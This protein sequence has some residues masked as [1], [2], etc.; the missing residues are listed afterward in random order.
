MSVVQHVIELSGADH[1][2]WRSL[3]AATYKAR[4]RWP[5]IDSDRR[6]AS[7]VGPSPI[8]YGI[9]GLV[10]CGLVLRLPATWTTTQVVL[11]IVMLVVFVS[12]LTE[13]GATLLHDEFGTLRCYPVSDRTFFVCR[14]TNLLRWTGTTVLFVATPTLILVLIREGPLFATGLAVTLALSS[15]FVAFASA[16]LFSVAAGLKTS[17]QPWAGAA[18]LLLGAV[19]LFASFAAPLFIDATLSPVV[20]FSAFVDLT[21]GAFA[22]R[23]VLA[24]TVAEGSTLCLLWAMERSWKYVWSAE[25]RVRQASNV[26]VDGHRHTSRNTFFNAL[27]TELRVCA[28]LTLSHLRHDQNLQLRLFVPLALG[29]AA[30]GLGL[31][32]Y[33]EVAPVVARLDAFMSLGLI[34]MA[35]IAVPLAWLSAFGRSDSFR[36]SWV[37]AVAPVEVG[38]IVFWSGVS[39]GVLGLP[40]LLLVGALLFVVLG[41]G[42]QAV[43]HAVSLALLVYGAINVALAMKPQVPLSKPA[44]SRDVDSPSR[45]VGQVAAWSAMF[46]L[47]PAGLSAASSEWWATAL[48]WLALTWAI[49]R[50]GRKV[51]ATGHSAARQH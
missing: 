12:L 23:T 2:Q 45:L 4:R 42:W 24:A 51:V 27:P 38:K 34:H 44:T 48:L 9:L 20:W 39:A 50:L 14:L 5:A 33:L 46:V 25:P 35:A 30:L 7:G 18:T 19:V 15:M 37:F 47:V 43:A 49:V 36:A 32:H 13:Y 8:A 16:T 3:T 22:V 6:S 31:M 28:R 11:A 1:R 17:A 26:R 21:T 10:F 41:G 29:L 40:F